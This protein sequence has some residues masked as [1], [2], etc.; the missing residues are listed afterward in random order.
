[1]SPREEYP[2]SHPSYWCS[3]SISITR[4]LGEEFVARD[5]RG[6][7]LAIGRLN[8]ASRPLERL[9]G[10]EHPKIPLLHV[11][12]GDTRRKRPRTRVSPIPMVPGEGTSIA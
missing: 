4:L 11:Q 9:V 7:P 8:T 6:V 1:M 12:G 2:S 3:L 5:G 10:T